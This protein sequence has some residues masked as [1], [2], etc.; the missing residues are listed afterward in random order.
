MTSTFGFDITCG[1][2]CAQCRRP[3]SVHWFASEMRCVWQ[4]VWLEDNKWHFHTNRV[5]RTHTL[6]HFARYKNFMKK[7]ETVKFCPQK[8]NEDRTE[9]ETAMENE[10]YKQSC[11]QTHKMRYDT[12]W[13][14]ILGFVSKN[15]TPMVCSCAIHRETWTNLNTY[16]CIHIMEC[17]KEA[18][19]RKP[20]CKKK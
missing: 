1:I 18:A 10:R 4:A 6:I 12:K 3:S 13:N 11:K 7:K 5:A 15:R 2:I 19:T 9:P 17:G 14:C 20:E 8:R 16:I